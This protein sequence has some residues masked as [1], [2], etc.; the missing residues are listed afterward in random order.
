MFGTRLTV[1]M[2]LALTV[3][4]QCLAPPGAA[5][6]A[7]PAETVP[8]ESWYTDA[9]WEMAQLGILTGPD[10]GSYRGDRALTRAELVAA[11]G[12]LVDRLG[13]ADLPE[14]PP[15]VVCDIGS[16]HWA[17]AGLARLLATGILHPQRFEDVDL[18]HWAAEGVAAVA[19][20]EPGRC[21][22]ILDGS[23]PLT[24][25]QYAQVVYGTHRAAGRSLATTARERRGTPEGYVVDEGILIGRPSGE[26]AFDQPMLRLEFAAATARFIQLMGQ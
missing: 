2:F 4:L 16:D 20:A 25:R 18:F 17:R 5:K 3:V 19:P 26:Y 21:Y 13:L 14:A 11:W 23:R 9:I 24:R 6:P 10:D 15:E 7:S 12:R 8:F 22:A 1:V